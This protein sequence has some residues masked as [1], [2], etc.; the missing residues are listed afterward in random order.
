MLGELRDRSGWFCR[1]GWRGVSYVF[2]SLDVDEMLDLAACHPCH[3]GLGLWRGLCMPSQL[4][5]PQYGLCQHWAVRSKRPAKLCNWF[6]VVYCTYSPCLHWRL[7]YLFILPC[8]GLA[9]L[10]T[11]GATYLLPCLG[12]FRVASLVIYLP[13]IRALCICIYVYVHVCIFNFGH[14]S[15]TLNGCA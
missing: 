14:Q 5:G 4:R 15:N 13:A 12:C 6:R 2:H 9:A 1:S 7:A 3:D 10:S 8:L 11:A